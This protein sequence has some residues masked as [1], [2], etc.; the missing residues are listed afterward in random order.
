MGSNVI[1]SHCELNL[2]SWWMMADDHVL[3]NVN[4]KFVANDFV[5]DD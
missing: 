5:A 1:D 2:S 4:G 3:V